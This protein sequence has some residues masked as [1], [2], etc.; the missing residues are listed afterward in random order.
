[1][2]RIFPIFILPPLVPIRALVFQGVLCSAKVVE[3]LV[4]EDEDKQTIATAPIA[5][6]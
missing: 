6:L 1:V 3:R 2:T 4:A 5:A